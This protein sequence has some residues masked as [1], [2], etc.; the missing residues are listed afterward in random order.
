MLKKTCFGCFQDWFRHW[1]CT[2][3]G[4]AILTVL[5]RE[6]EK[7]DISLQRRAKSHIIRGW[8]RRTPPQTIF[9]A[10]PCGNIME[11]ERGACSSLTFLTLT[12]HNTFALLREEALSGEMDFSLFSF[13]NILM[14]HQSGSSFLAQLN[15]K[16]V[17][18]AGKRSLS[19]GQY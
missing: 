6:Q 3:S 9:K 12:F 17:P 13:Q 10:E 19:E 5:E 18:N 16:P 11:R 1:I 4:A 14:C 15:T 2:T 8:T 7:R